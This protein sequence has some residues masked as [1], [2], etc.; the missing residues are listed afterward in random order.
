MLKLSAIKI[1]KNQKF[2]PILWAL[3]LVILFFLYIDLKHTRFMMIE[4]TNNML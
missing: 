2:F 1:S 3:L 4:S